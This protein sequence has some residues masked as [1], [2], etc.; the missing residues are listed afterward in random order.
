[1]L[2]NDYLGN[3]L[4]FWFFFT[5]LFDWH[6]TLSILCE[7]RFLEHIS[8]S[9]LSMSKL[10]IYCYIHICSYSTYCIPFSEIT[11]VFWYSKK[12]QWLYFSSV[13]YIVWYIIS[14]RCKNQRMLVKSRSF[15][16]YRG[17]FFPFGA[18]FF[19]AAGVLLRANSRLGFCLQPSLLIRC[20]FHP[21]SPDAMFWWH[22]GQWLLLA[23]AELQLLAAICSS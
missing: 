23:L 1:M 5:P 18:A 13:K 6:N 19:P 20:D 14:Q 10:Y 7:K 2:I 22:R 3:V 16:V 11:S 15:N 12:I 8:S 4:R 9:T 17:V 21:S